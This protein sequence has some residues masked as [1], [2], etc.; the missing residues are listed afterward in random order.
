M[1]STAAAATRGGQDNSTIIPRL[2]LL[3]LPQECK[4]HI[5]SCLPLHDLL[6]LGAASKL[7]L[8]D[9]LYD[10][11]R[12]RQKLYQTFFFDDN[13]YYDRSTDRQRHP[14]LRHS[15]HSLET[16]TNAA[17]F[18]DTIALLPHRVPS[19]LEQVVELAHCL[20]HQHPMAPHVQELC[21]ELMKHDDCI[22]CTIELQLHALI[23]LAR[24]P[25]TTTNNS[26]SGSGSSRLLEEEEEEDAQPNGGDGVVIVL[27]PFTH[28]F[29][30]LKRLSKPHRLHAYILNF[31]MADNP[32]VSSNSKNN[33]ARRQ[34]TRAHSPGVRTMAHHR[35]SYH[36]QP[37][38][39]AALNRNNLIAHGGSD[40]KNNTAVSLDRYLG[41]VLCLAHLMN[42]SCLQLVEG[43]PHD[44]SCLYQQRHHATSSTTQQLH[45]YQSWIFMH[46]IIL[47]S[48]NLQW[49]V[50]VASLTSSRMMM[51]MNQQQQQQQ[52]QQHN[53]NLYLPQLLQQQRQQQQR[54][55]QP[56]NP[57]IHG[58]PQRRIPYDCYYITDTFLS[59]EMTLIFND[60]GPP[61]HPERGRDVVHI[62]TMTAQQL[63]GL[64][65]AVTTNTSSL[66]MMRQGRQHRHQRDN[67]ARMAAPFEF[68]PNNFAM[69]D[70]EDLRGGGWD[71]RFRHFMDADEDEQLEEDWMPH[72][73]RR[74][75]AE[76]HFTQAQQWALDWIRLV[77]EQ[78]GKCRPMS[79]RP[80]AVRLSV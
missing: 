53:G 29:A 49:E 68:R 62:R 48:T 30:M 63:F 78:C 41:D 51:M 27:A 44:T 13:N 12:R 70:D 66:P 52:Q 33:P 69:D 5:F 37:N 23:F 42:Q 43:G 21:H 38:M 59:S 6:T 67:P 20:P 77:H 54:Q 64:Y 2:S 14:D 9:S 24:H 8:H 36:R 25:T 34:T 71:Q 80:P 57:N 58:P 56:R 65:V 28:L 60:F 17:S 45:A 72:N 74:D 3:D 31:V 79:V 15:H 35:H 7:A 1:N 76:G 10:L 26:G 32:F 61:S 22:D 11:N 47:Q 39:T 40:D 50:A 46:S 75:A 16:R 19:V 4:I 73:Q 18:S 55:Q